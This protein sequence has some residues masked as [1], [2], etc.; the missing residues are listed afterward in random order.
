[1]TD[2]KRAGGL[3]ATVL[4]GGARTMGKVAGICWKGPT[5]LIRGFRGSPRKNIVFPDALEAQ[6]SRSPEDVAG[7]I[8]RSGGGISLSEIGHKFGVPWQ[9]LIPTIKDLLQADRIVKKGRRYFPA[10]P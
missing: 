4:F 6:L 8:Q 7:V 1:M 5:G 3:F 10:E 2:S 9:S